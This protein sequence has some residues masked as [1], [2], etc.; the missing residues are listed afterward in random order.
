MPISSVG[1]RFG[2]ALCEKYSGG[3]YVPKIAVTA[4]CDFLKIGMRNA[5][6]LL[7]GQVFIDLKNK[8]IDLKIQKN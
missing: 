4:H 7:L 8:K 5:L 1:P 3:L 2:G 6:L